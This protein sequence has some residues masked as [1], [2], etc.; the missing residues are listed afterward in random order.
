VYSWNR[1]VVVLRAMVIG[2]CTDSYSETFSFYFRNANMHG[3]D[4][5]VKV[6]RAPPFGSPPPAPV[7]APPVEVAPVVAPRRPRAKTPFVA[8]LLDF[9]AAEHD[10]AFL[11]MSR[12]FGASPADF[13]GRPIGCR[14]HFIDFLLKKCGNDI[15]HPCLRSVVTLR[16]SPPAGG[17]TDGGGG[18]S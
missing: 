3:L 2:K 18:S 4:A 8:V 7:S 5:P 1:A 17:M 13:H 9:E 6:P 12:T 10:G 14:V 16:D 15:H 11:E